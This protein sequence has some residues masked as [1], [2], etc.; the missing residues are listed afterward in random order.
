MIMVLYP[1]GSSNRSGR[2]SSDVWFTP[3]PRWGMYSAAAGE[4]QVAVAV[5]Q[6]DVVFAVEQVAAPA[7]Q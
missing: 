5:G 4:V 3:S 7:E 2:G 6:F 1:D